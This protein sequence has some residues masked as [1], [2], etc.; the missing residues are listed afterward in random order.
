M[1]RRA[2][3]PRMCRSVSSASGAEASGRTARAAR[4]VGDAQ[5][6]QRVGQHQL[7]RGLGPGDV[8]LIEPADLPGGEPMRRDRLDE[9]HAVGRVGARQRHEVLHRGVRDE[10]AV[11][12]VL[13]DRVGE[14][15]APDS[16]AAT[17]SSRCDRSAAPARRAP[18]RAPRAACAAASPARSALSVASVCSSCRKISASGS[19]ISHDD[20]AHRVA[21]AG[22][23]G[24]GR[25]CGRPPRRTRAPS[26]RPRSASAD[27]RR[28]TTPTAGVRAPAAAPAAL[29]AQIELMKFQVHRCSVSGASGL[30]P[31]H[32]SPAAPHATAHRRCSAATTRDASRPAPQRR[33]CR[34]DRGGGNPDPSRG[35]APDTPADGRDDQADLQRSVGDADVQHGHRRAGPRRDTPASSRRVRDRR[36]DKWR[37]SGR[38]LGTCAPEAPTPRG[39][40]A[41]R[42]SSTIDRFF[43]QNERRLGRPAAASS[44]SRGPGGC[45][46]RS[47]PRSAAHT[48]SQPPAQSLSAS[49][50]ESSSVRDQ[51]LKVGGPILASN[52]GSILASAEASFWRDLR[53]YVCAGKSVR[54][55]PVKKEV[56]LTIRETLVLPLI[57]PSLRFPSSGACVQHRSLSIGTHLAITLHIRVPDFSAA[58]RTW[59][60]RDDRAVIGDTLRFRS[61]AR[62]SLSCEHFERSKTRANPA[63]KHAARRPSTTTLPPHF[64]TR[65]A[66]CGTGT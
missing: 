59:L 30:E 3:A 10:L 51:S 64:D 4:V 55:Q 56:Q 57:H 12:H 9:A 15:R 65:T 23:G 58:N 66:T 16:G 37:R 36:T 62:Q 29:V 20:G 26:S 33:V 61:R 40:S 35:G 27:R 8:D 7:A 50:T 63:R 2:T 11:V 44:R 54:K 53:K 1:A 42:A 28:P 41:E 45:C 46:S 6:E 43:R 25:A 39:R 31:V 32:G 14:R 21:R 18:G 5:H 52:P 34:I 47:S 48:L 60:V 19:A 13:L 38:T 49:P 24:S 22:D 17:P